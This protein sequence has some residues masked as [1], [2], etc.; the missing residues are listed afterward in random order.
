MR[1]FWGRTE[2]A[3][4]YSNLLT[5]EPREAAALR[6]ATRKAIAALAL[7]ESSSDADRERVAHAVLRVA[8]SGF[9]RASNG[10]LNPDDIALAAVAR[11]RATAV[12]GTG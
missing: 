8:Q 2:A 7:G 9:A 11:V 10:A 5:I 12:G 3:L 4:P 6:D 1:I